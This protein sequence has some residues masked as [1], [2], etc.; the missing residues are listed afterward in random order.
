MLICVVFVGGSDVF[1]TFS[2]LFHRLIS[3][4][5]CCITQSHPPFLPSILPSCL[6]HS[7][8]P[9]LPLLHSISLS[10]SYTATRSHSVDFTPLHLP[11]SIPDP[12][13]ITV[14]NPI[15]RSPHFIPDPH[16]NGYSGPPGIR[17][18]PPGH[19]G[20]LTTCI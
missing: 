14:Q 18:P 17:P 11:P 4:L 5:L 19:P 9:S 20:N 2:I 10:L 12:N 6:P 16:T 7:L 1:C 13:S 8:P 15:H 3:C